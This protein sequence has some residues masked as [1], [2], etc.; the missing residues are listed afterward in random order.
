M[1]TLTG[2]ASLGGETAKGCASLF[3]PSI[4]QY[5]NWKGHTKNAVVGAAKKSYINWQVR[6]SNV[7]GRDMS[8]SVYDILGILV[9]TVSPQAS[10]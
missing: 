8:S 6:P 10:E 9:I 5:L 3:I 7:L 1:A 2:K 4:L